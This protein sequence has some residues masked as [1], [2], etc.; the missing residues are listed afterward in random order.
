M[1]TRMP[2]RWLSSAL[3]LAFLAQGTAWSEEEKQQKRRLVQPQVAPATQPAK[4][5]TQTAPSSTQTKPQTAPIVPGRRSITGW[6]MKVTPERKSV[7]IRTT[8]T[9]YEVFVTA[10][11]EVTRDSRPASLKEIRPSDRVDA[12]HFNAKHVVQQ[13][14]LTSGESLGVVPRPQ[15]N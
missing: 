6:V 9:E 10:Q 3:L 13:L 12:C 5:Q 8:T 7:H 4:A 1:G 11:T 14:T 15:K 2:P